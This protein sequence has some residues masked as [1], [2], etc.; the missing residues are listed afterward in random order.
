MQI[1]EYFALLFI[2]LIILKSTTKPFNVLLALTRSLI[3]NYQI[4]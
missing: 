2:S 3:M 1:I 4:N